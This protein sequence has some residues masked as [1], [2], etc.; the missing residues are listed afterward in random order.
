MSDDTEYPYF[1]S[2]NPLET[3][4]VDTWIALWKEF[5]FKRVAFLAFEDEY[6]RSTMERLQ[7]D[8]VAAEIELVGSEFATLDDLISEG[9]TMR[10]LQRLR[11]DNARVILIHGYENHSRK[12][13]C[14]AYKLG[15]TG[16]GY[17]YFYASWYA[18]D[19]WMPDSNVDCTVEE[20]YNATRYMIGSDPK[21]WGPPETGAVFV[22]LFHLFQ[23]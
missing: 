22:Y 20:M 16:V 12:V 9:G 4:H 1:F 15:M 6:F 8:L 23:S 7:E 5:G 11:D 14:D 10:Y 18:E 21:Q 2:I 13:M 17:A 19:W 3:Q